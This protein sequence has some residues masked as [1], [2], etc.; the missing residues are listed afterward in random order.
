[1]KGDESPHECH[2]ST[3]SSA[4]KARVSVMAGIGRS[5]QPMSSQRQDARLTFWRTLRNRGWVGVKEAYGKDRGFL[6]SL[7]YNMP[8]TSFYL[9]RRCRM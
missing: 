4:M 2:R 7:L 9:V 6:L 8:G 1:M 5:V 3:M